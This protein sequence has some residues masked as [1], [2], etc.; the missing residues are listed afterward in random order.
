MRVTSGGVLGQI[1]D[2]GNLP[3][4][5]DVTLTADD[6]VIGFEVDPELKAI[7]LEA[8]AGCDR[9]EKISANQLLREL[10]SDQ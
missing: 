10:Q 4:D 5:S 6:H 1:G 9:G 3:E 2:G 8:V 7:L